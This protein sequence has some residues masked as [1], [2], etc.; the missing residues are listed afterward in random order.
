MDKQML[1]DDRMMEDVM[2]DGDEGQDSRMAALEQKRKARET[3]RQF[4]VEQKQEDKTIKKYLKLIERMEIMGTRDTDATNELDVAN[5]LLSTQAGGENEGETLSDFHTDSDPE[6][7]EFGDPIQPWEKFGK[8]PE[9][10]EFLQLKDKPGGARVSDEELSQVDPQYEHSDHAEVTMMENLDPTMEDIEKLSPKPDPI[11]GPV[12]FR[13]P[14]DVKETIFNLNKISPTKYHSRKL[15]QMFGLSVVRTQAILKLQYMED[16]MINS[17]GVDPFAAMADAEAE[18]I[19]K[20]QPAQWDPDLFFEN[21]E[22]FGGRVLDSKTGDDGELEYLRKVERQ[23]NDRYWKREER[24]VLKE[25]AMA[26]R[27]GMYGADPLPLPAP[28][29]LSDVVQ[30][31]TKHTVVLTDISDFKK[32]NYRIVARDGEGNLREPNEAEFKRVRFR[33]RCTWEFFHHKPYAFG[34]K[35]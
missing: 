8:N 5:A 3:K 31:K 11:E 24:E 27:K 29:K 14:R 16:Q 28:L 15:A 1:E 21:I 23:R 19:F 33:E 25:Q 35:I 10:L 6:Y 22:T 9:G 26:M 18:H 12:I 2:M 4:Q 30:G 34:E 32:G 7:N 20:P 17:T 13:I